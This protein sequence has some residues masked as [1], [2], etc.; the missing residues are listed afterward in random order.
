[1]LTKDKTIKNKNINS[2]LNINNFSNSKII[3]TSSLPLYSGYDLGQRL[4]KNINIKKI[5]SLPNSEKSKIN[6]LNHNSINKNRSNQEN[7]EHI[8]N[9]N[10]IN[11]N[12]INNNNTYN[13]NITNN[14]KIYNKFDKIKNIW[15]SNKNF[16][17]RRNKLFPYKYYFCSIFIKNIDISKESIFFNKK[18]IAVYIFICQLFDV[19]SYFLLQREFQ[20]LKNILV[21]EKY[22]DFIESNRK[23][24]VNDQLFN[25]NMKE[26]LTSHK[27]SIFS[28]F[29]KPNQ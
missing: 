3:E 12:N 10:Y 21:G 2:Q 8:K 11:N 18:F 26:C 1:M 16:Y 14:N 5:S 22:K 23:I 20:I 6:S 17:Y 15:N 4:F 24:N 28:K 27:L 9:N 29:Q 19:S 13:Y 7:I 25:I